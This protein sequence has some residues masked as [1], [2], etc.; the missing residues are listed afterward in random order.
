ME[1]TRNWM[2]VL[3]SLL[4]VCWAAPALAGLDLLYT[5]GE[6]MPVLDS[7]TGAETNLGFISGWFD[8]SL[9]GRYSA[10]AFTIDEDVVIDEVV[11]YWFDASDNAVLTAFDTLEW[12][13]HADDVGGGP[14]TIVA[15]GTLAETDV[16]NE[17][18]I[19]P[20]GGAATDWKRRF[21]FHAELSA[22]SYWVSFHGIEGA[23]AWLTGAIDGSDEIY[24]ATV[25]DDYS[26]YTTDGWETPD[27]PGRLYHLAFELWGSAGGLPCEGDANGDGLVDPLDS[28]FVLARFGCP[29]GTG[30]PLCDIADQNG[31]G[32]VDPLD[33]G[34]VLARF[35]PCE[36]AAMQPASEVTFDTV[37]PTRKTESG[38]NAIE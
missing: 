10:T 34:F 19:E 8:E 31:D 35:G 18:W 30:D 25:G 36:A 37:A 29:V 20:V 15:T 23:L 14:G 38:P 13:F 32:V 27:D 7:G 28:G 12:V 16:I 22:G 26:L 6:P 2:T 21:T 11:A 33:V 4:T 9:P 3:V 5:T 1:R 17:E 24:R